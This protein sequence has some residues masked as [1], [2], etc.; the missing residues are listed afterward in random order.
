MWASCLVDGTS[1]AT[2][3]PGPTPSAFVTPISNA[4]A[5]GRREGERHLEG[6]SVEHELCDFDG[7]DQEANAVPEEHK[8]QA[9][10]HELD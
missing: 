6:D 8:V 5:N 9:Q 10:P 2:L 7:I 1:L 4:G 3:G